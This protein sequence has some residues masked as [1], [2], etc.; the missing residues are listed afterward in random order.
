MH[1]APARP[2]TLQGPGRGS[3]DL[4]IGVSRRLKHG[5]SAPTRDSPGARDLSRRNTG[6][7]DARGEISRPLLERTFLRSKVRAP[8]GSDRG[9]S[10][11][12]VCVLPQLAREDSRALSLAR[13]LRLGTS[14]A[15]FARSAIALNRYRL[16]NRRNN[17]DPVHGLVAES[18]NRGRYL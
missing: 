8:L 10:H 14:R 16:E 4:P 17:A 2:L 9:V 13:P 18:R 12:A 15:P 3:A 7:G 1:S 11:S 5:Y 6:T